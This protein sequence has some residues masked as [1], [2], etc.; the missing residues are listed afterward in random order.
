MRSLP[1]ILRA[2]LFVCLSVSALHAQSPATAGG[3]AINGA[4]LDPSGAAIPGATLHLH[5]TNLDRETNTDETGHFVLS[6]PAATYQLIVSA[7]GFS[8]VLRQ[9]FVVNATRNAPLNVTLKIAT[10]AEQVEVNGDNSLSTEG[11]ANKS[12]LAFTG[13]QLDTF[14]DDPTIMQQELEAVGGTDPS[15]PP[16]IFVDGFSNGTLPPKESIREIRIN[17]N[18]LS[19]QYDQFGGGRIEIF[20][21]PGSTTLHGHAAGN[22]GDSALNSNNPFA[23]AEPAYHN[24]YIDADFN[25]PLGKKTSFYFTV[26]RNDMASNAVVDATTLAGPIKEAISAPVLTQTYTARIEH[27]FGTHDTFI[28]RYAFVDNSITNGGVGQFVL[29]SAGYNSDTHT[30]TLQL[31]DTHLFGPK[32]VS[33]SAFQYIRTRSRQDSLSTAPALVVQGAFSSGGSPSQALHDDLDRLEFREE[34]S[35]AHGTHFIRTG[36]R[37]RITRDANLATAGYNGQFTFS[38]LTAYQITEQGLAA[39]Q[40]DAQIRA[41]CVT[42]TDGTQTCG[43]ATQ[44]S[45]SAGVPSASLLTTDI[46]VYGEDEWKL[47]AQPHTHLRSAS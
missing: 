16:Q 40:T 27:Q 7:Q 47:H 3:V 17:Q 11:S 26:I 10:D 39:G 25:G 46:G 1:R 2:C 19:A 37:Y 22:F 23:G 43:G 4:V 15:N 34:L 42:G 41:T 6:A 24:S 31:T 14:S 45:L 13:E 8:T 32:I 35:I 36:G 28:G 18:P 38:S 44:L 20:T 29:P 33:D 30:Q 21:K 12:A 9:G 5:S